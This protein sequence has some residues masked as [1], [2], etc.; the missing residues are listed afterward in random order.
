MVT[1]GG[2]V[3]PFFNV[4]TDGDDETPSTLVDELVK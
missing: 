2:R 4:A 3:P 1:N